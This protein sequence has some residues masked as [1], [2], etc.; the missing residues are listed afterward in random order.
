[1]PKPS[2]WPNNNDAR[3]KKSH[4]T[5][6]RCFLS[7]LNDME[8]TAGRL[9]TTGWKYVLPTEAQWEYACRAGNDHHFFLGNDINSTQANYNWDGG[10]GRAEPKSRQTVN[11]GQY[12]ANPWGFFD[13][14]G[15]VWE[16]VHDWKAE[17]SRWFSG[18]IEGPASGSFRVRRGGSGT[19]A[20]RTCV[21]LSA[22]TA[23]PATEPAAL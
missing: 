3:L 20:G 5:I 2:H 19:T 10:G 8:Q 9:P 7:R 15:N 1:M 17:L 4:G 18:P 13:M 22:A 21:Q 11:V 6:F 12:A 16:W 14:H 23:P